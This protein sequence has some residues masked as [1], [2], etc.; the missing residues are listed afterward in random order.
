MRSNIGVQCDLRSSV[1]N[2]GGQD[3]LKLNFEGKIIFK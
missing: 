2:C 3:K 1:K